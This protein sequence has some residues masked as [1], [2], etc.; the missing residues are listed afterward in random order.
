MCQVFDENRILGRLLFKKYTLKEPSE[1]V[2]LREMNEFCK[3]NRADSKK[4]LSSKHD[5]NHKISGL[6]QNIAFH[7]NISFF[8][9]FI[10]FC[11]VS[12]FQRKS[13]PRTKYIREVY[14]ETT[15]GGR[16]LREMNDF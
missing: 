4:K 1:N 7:R 3:M 13:N 6:E 16:F 8:V 12:N 9:I 11:Y 2:F 14:I 10:V 15:I 5:K